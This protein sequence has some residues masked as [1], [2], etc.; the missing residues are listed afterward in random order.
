MSLAEPI[1]GQ[2]SDYPES[3]LREVTDVQVA[4]RR[5]APIKMGELVQSHVDRWLVGMPFP[6]AASAV[7]TLV[8][9]VGVSIEPSS[10]TKTRRL[11]EALL[12]EHQ[13]SSVGV[14]LRVS[15]PVPP[16]M[17][18]GTSTTSMKL[19]AQ[20]T[21][22]AMGIMLDPRWLGEAMARIEPCDASCSDGRLVLWEFKRGQPL[23]G[24]YPLAQ[25]CYVAAYPRGRALDTDIVDRARPVYASS[26]A[27]RLEEI[28]REL[29]TVLQNAAPDRLSELT[30]ISADIN[31]TYF[32]KPE[33]R[34]LRELRRSGA[35]LGY[36]VAHSGTVV[37]ALGRA[38]TLRRTFDD[39]SKGLGP[40]YEVFGFEHDADTM[41]V[42]F[43]KGCG[44]RLLR[45]ST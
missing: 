41:G 12:E 25:A 7:A 45:V 32:Q 39:F 4:T 20:A 23:S 9:E 24:E 18:C 15:L 16:G 27:R 22:D 29:P 36:F 40:G 1:A 30:S 42:P 26:E 11:C 10:F 14:R 3:H 17:G 28:Y 34:M 37:G 38:G 44:Q 6:L 5:S 43:L 8:D 13:I 33:L 19:G 21:A 35:I 2:L 31:D